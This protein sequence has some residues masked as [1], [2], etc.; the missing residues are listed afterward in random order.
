MAYYSDFTIDE[1]GSDYKAALSICRYA[2]LSGHRTASH[3]QP[4]QA[5]LTAFFSQP[6]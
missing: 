5:L 3:G 6:L 4:R 1:Y 2:C